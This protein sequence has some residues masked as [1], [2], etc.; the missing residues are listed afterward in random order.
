[1]ALNLWQMMGQLKMGIDILPMTD[2]AEVPH[3]Y[4]PGYVP[5]YYLVVKGEDNPRTGDIVDLVEYAHSSLKLCTLYEDGYPV[6][7]V[8]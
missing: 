3:A 5:T 2:F 1:M 8:M 6:M 7:E 4:T